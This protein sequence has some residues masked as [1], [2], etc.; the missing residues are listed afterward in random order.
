MRFTVGSLNQTKIK[1]V[2]DAVAEIELFHGAQVEGVLIAL[3]EFGHPKNLEEVTTGAI[4]RA[5]AAFQNCDL[6]FGLEG[7]LMAVPHTR[8]GYMEVSMCAIFDG[9]RFYLGLSPGFEWPV[10][11]LELILAG[12]DG[13]QAL[14]EAGLTDHQKLGTAGGVVGLL[15]R[16]RMNRD[17]YSKYSVMMALV[18]LENK[19]YYA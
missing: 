5:R 4:N 13:S 6:S 9:T 19:E 1:A 7:G 12:R 8:T 11:C 16:G 10:T 3:E 17:L 18:Q 15:T 2:A 14:R